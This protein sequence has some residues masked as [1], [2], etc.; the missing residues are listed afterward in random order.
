MQ[1]VERLIRKEMRD[2]L[3]GEPRSEPDI[4]PLQRVISGG[5]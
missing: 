1:C 5:C 3:S 4:I 2:P